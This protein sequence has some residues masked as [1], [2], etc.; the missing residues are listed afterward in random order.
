MSPYDET[1]ER[2][3]FERCDDCG[4]PFFAC[5][6]PNLC[7]NEPHEEEFA[8]AECNETKSERDP[9]IPF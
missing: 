6:C 8:D 2:F 3:Y 5:L 1:V 4:Y 7:D 9:Q